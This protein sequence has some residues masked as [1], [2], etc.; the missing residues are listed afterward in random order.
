MSEPDFR[1]MGD[2]LNDRLPPRP[3]K[4]PAPPFLS[5]DCEGSNLV[6]HPTWR[7][8]LMGVGV[9]CQMCGQ[10]FPPAHRHDAVPGHKRPDILAMLERGDF[11]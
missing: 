2:P 7:G 1:K 5:V 6:G 11:G 3:R 10:W 4:P 8:D 9:M